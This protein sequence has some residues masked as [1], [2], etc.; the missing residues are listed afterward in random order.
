MKTGA[1][2]RPFRLN[3]LFMAIASSSLFPLVRLDL[4]TLTFFAAGHSTSVRVHL[5]SATHYSVYQKTAQAKL[6]TN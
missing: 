1:N 6:L 4:L 3:L 5:N 2:R